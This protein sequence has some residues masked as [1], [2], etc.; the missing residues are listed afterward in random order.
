M[1]RACFAL[2]VLP[3][4]TDAA[5]AFMRDLETTRRDEYSASEQRIG[6]E[7]E[8]WFLQHTEQGDLYV[9]YMESPDLGRAFE[10]FCNSKDP[11]DIWFKEQLL[12]AT[13][14]DLNVVPA[15]PLSEQLSG[16]EVS[17]AAIAR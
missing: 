17:Q 1:E 7:R 5:R 6:I 3:S 10:L 9:A 15:G 11:F 8:F 14:V 16:Y 4:M 2:P 12:A 13:G